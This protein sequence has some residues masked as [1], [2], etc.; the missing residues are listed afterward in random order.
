MSASITRRRWW[1]TIG[2]RTREQPGVDFLKR[3]PTWWD[4]T[5]VLADQIG[6]LLVVARRKGKSWYVGG[7]SAGQSREL[8]LPL[9]F[10]G[11][12]PHSATI[13]KDASGAEQDPNK[14]TTETLNLSFPDPLKLHL[15]LDGGFVAHF[16]PMEK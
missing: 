9:A 1:R 13:W 16:A 3:V 15:A 12:G 7:M 11:A 8:T 10:L 4:E 14:L 6:E 2:R 5:R